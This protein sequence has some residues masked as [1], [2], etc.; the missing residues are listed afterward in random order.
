MMPA[1]STA[2]CFTSWAIS[3]CALALRLSSWSLRNR[4][5]RLSA[6]EVLASLAKPAASTSRALSRPKLAAFWMVLMASTGAG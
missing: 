6:T 1:P 4:P 2:A 5:I 3:S